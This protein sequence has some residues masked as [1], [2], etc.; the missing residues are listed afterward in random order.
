MVLQASLNDM[1]RATPP[2]EPSKRG[3]LTTVAI[4]ST[5]AAGLAAFL[6]NVDKI[7]AEAHKACQF[8]G[9]CAATLKP[10]PALAGHDSDWMGGGH[11]Q[12]EQ[13]NPLLEK[14][15]AENPDFNITLKSWEESNKDF[16]GHT[17]YRYHCRYAATPK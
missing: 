14:Y 16:V 13:C 11:N 1:G 15:R 10:T 5:G 6:S 2:R 12:G 8:A 7:G 9:V 17:T 4:I 3:W